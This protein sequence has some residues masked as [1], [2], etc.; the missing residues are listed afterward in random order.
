MPFLFPEEE[1]QVSQQGATSTNAMDTLYEDFLKDN[2]K[3][4][5][6]S[7]RPKPCIEQTDHS[8][9]DTEL[10]QPRTVSDSSPPKHEH[11]GESGPVLD[12][13]N[14][15]Q[16][17]GVTVRK[18]TVS[19]SIGT[20]NS[21]FV[22]GHDGP[23]SISG[24]IEEISDEEIKNNRETEEGIRNIPRFKNYQKGAPSNV[25]KAAFEMFM[26]TTSC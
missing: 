13:D 17:P 20:L 15:L 10:S 21:T 9:S 18:M 16:S 8:C 1:S 14:Q 11:L 19:Q 25:I 12:T 2:N 5:N 6:I 24:R 7:E 26:K 3:K 23:V 4:S 22:Q